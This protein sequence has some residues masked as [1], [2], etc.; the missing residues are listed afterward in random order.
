MIR[1]DH[2]SAI[3]ELSESEGVFT[4]AQA[5]HIGIPRDALHDA[6]EAG[7][8]ERV[9]R[10]A[11]RLIGSGSR[12]TD[13]LAAIWKL[14]NAA[15]F[16]YERAQADAWDGIAVGGATAASVLGIGDF[17]LSPYRI[18]A[19]KRINSRNGAARFGVRRIERDDITFEYDVPVT[20]PERTVFDLILDNEDGSLVADALGDA[21]SATPQFDFDRLRELLDSRFGAKKG[22]DLF[23]SLM[24]DARL[25]TSSAGLIIR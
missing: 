19:P 14:T 10:G 6:V 23:E 24:L 3:A 21:C 18:F 20:R 8:L 22:T 5:A 13:E 12:E 25:D 7:R 4:T 9:V 17:F 11:Y 1:N 15:K 16:S 2:I